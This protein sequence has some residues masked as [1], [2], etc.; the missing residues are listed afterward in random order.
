MTT[1]DSHNDIYAESFHRDFFKNW[2]QGIEPRN[3]AGE[4]GHN[5]A[6]IGGLVM[7]NAVILLHYNDR[8]LA[9]ERTLEHLR[10]THKSEKLEAYV[11]KYVDLLLDALHSSENFEDFV[12]NHIDTAAKAVGISK[13]SEM[14]LKLEDIEFIGG[15]V[16][17][18]CYIEHSFPCTL[19]LIGK[20]GYS[21]ENCLIANV[22]AGGENCH[23]GSVVGSL[24]G[25]MNGYKQIPEKWITGLHD[26]R[27]IAD[28]IEK[29]V[30]LVI[31]EN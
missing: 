19:F 17:S 16:S 30:N 28:E 18:A 6:Q 14:R 9:Q 15:L 20:H 3:C 2:S 31:P 24:V 7:L 22:N 29:F 12:K 25:A 1:K 21:I 11:E 23:R 26:Y 13:F 27:E 10:L 4:E 5:T 8:K